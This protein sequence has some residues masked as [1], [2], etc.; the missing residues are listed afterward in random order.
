MKLVQA[1]NHED[2][3]ITA[4]YS[5]DDGGRTLYFV[6]VYPASHEKYS[7]VYTG[8]DEALQVARAL[9]NNITR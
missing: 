6:D 8:R 3:P 1:H 5:F 4:V 2:T 9:F 7:G